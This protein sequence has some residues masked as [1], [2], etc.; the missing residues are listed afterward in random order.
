MNVDDTNVGE[1]FMTNGC[2]YF[3]R[4]IRIKFKK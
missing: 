1:H 2:Y 3:I 4:K